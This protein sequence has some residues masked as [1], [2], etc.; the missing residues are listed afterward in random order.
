[1]R[2]RRRIAEVR[3]R[4]RDVAAHHGLGI[5]DQLAQ[6][7]V[8]GSVGVVLAHDP[9]RG[10]AQLNQRAGG[11]LDHLG[12]PAR[13]GWIATSHAFSHLHQRVLGMAGLGAS[14]R[15]SLIWESVSL[16]PNQVPYQNRKGNS[17][18]SSANTVIR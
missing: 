16:R 15:Y 10:L 5:G 18:S 9:G 13:G 4:Q 3:K 8:E 11:K 7:F 14:A 17:T 2:T 12:I 1:M 6:R